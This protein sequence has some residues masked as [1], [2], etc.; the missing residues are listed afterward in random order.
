VSNW[1]RL[2]GPRGLHQHQSVMP[3][4]A[5]RDVVPALIAAAQA[6][7]H[8]SFLTVLK[9][10]GDIAS[11]GLISFPRPGFTLTLDFPNRGSQTAALLARLDAMTLDAGGAVNPY[12]DARMSADVFAR[13]F[14]QWPRLEALRDPAFISDFWRRAAPLSPPEA[15]QG[16]RAA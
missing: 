6:A 5:A 7:G 4:E 15:A 13:S 10:F 16:S 2:Y 1:N 3:E 11:P 9:R 8:G 14:P 12:K